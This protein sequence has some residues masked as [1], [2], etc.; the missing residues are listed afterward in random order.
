MQLIWGTVGLLGL[1]LAVIGTVLPIMPTV[2]FLIVAAFGFARS[3][4]R[5]H[6]R[7]MNHPVFGPQIHDWQEYRAISTRVKYIVC[8]SMA[9]G[10]CVSFFLLPLP[11]WLGQVVVLALVA[12]FVVTRNSPPGAA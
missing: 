8:L 7:I 2:P 4:P 1:V 6:R 12:L 10:L 5:L 11:F 9:G 3:S